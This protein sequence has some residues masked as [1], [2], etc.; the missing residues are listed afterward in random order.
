[1]NVGI[2]FVSDGT[3]RLDEKSDDLARAFATAAILQAHWLEFEAEYRRQ[4]DRLV[5]AELADLETG[6]AS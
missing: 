4:R 6:G 3:V 5:A 2:V 1:V